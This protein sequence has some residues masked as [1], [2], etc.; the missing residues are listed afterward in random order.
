MKAA[1]LVVGLGVAALGVFMA[2]ETSQFQVSPLYAKV[3]PQVIPYIIAA[4][5]ILFGVLFAA[6]AARASKQTPTPSGEAVEQAGR[7]DWLALV[8]ISVGL[9]AQMLLL[10]RAGFV[11]AAAVLFYC[12]AFGFGSRRYLRD[13]IIA[14]LLAVIV[15]VGFTRG[16]NLQLPAGVLAGRL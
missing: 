3:G 5:L 2:V 14:I 12:V 6:S 11:I 16:L 8:V 7:S 15:Y 10:E 13:G 4:G 1:E 9:I